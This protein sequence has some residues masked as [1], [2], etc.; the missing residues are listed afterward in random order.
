MQRFLSSGDATQA[1]NTPNWRLKGNEG[2]R[3]GAYLAAGVLFK[4]DNDLVPSPNQVYVQRPYFRFA[5]ILVDQGEPQGLHATH[6]ERRRLRATCRPRQGNRK[7]DVRLGQPA[8]VQ[9][10]CPRRT[11]GEDHL[12]RL[13]LHALELSCLN[14]ADEL[15]SEKGEDPYD[16]SANQPNDGPRK[17]HHQPGRFG[18]GHGLHHLYLLLVAA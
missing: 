5:G 13:R 8:P 1:F 7:P 11:A 15:C 14:R 9:W 18:Q 16:S 17:R 6:V 10:R 2:R 3:S 4:R 12:G